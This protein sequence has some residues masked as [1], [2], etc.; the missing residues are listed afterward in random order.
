MM[1]IDDEKDMLQGL[2]RILPQ[3]LEGVDVETFSSAL[4]GLESIKKQSVDVL[5]LDI[6]MPE[7]DGMEVLTAVKEI[8]PWITVVMITAYGSIETAVEAIK[9]GAYDFITKPFEIPDLVRVLNKA[10]ERS[11]LIRENMNLRKKVSEREPFADFVGQ[12]PPM[13]RLYDGI[14]ALAGTDYTV[15]IRG[16]SGTGKEL[17]ARALHELSP[18][19]SRRMVTVNCP[20]IPEHLL[21]SE[22]FGHKKGAFTGAEQNHSGMFL[23]ADQSTLLLDE[24]GD[25]P[26]STQIKLLRVLQEREVRPLGSDKPRKVDVRILSCTNQDLEARIQDRSFRD[27]LYY[28]LNVV[29]LRTPSL[30]EITEDIPLLADHFLRSVCNELGLPQKRFSVAAIQSMMHKSWPGN[31]RELQNFLRRVALFSPE[32]EIGAADIRA[33]QDSLYGSAAESRQ[34]E[35]SNGK[36]VKPYQQAKEELLENF[37]REY[38]TRLLGQTEGN[39][40]RASDIAGI[41]RTALQKIMRRYEIRSEDFR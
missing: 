8:D 6:R 36:A 19:S 33:A 4:S 22:L 31:V 12:S 10:L 21:E 11:L 1:I 5:L 15:L 13:R 23:E 17:V 38:I 40:T 25:L 27:D 41:S 32:E 37:T 2:S 14:Q 20:A 35:E 26:V 30:S 28:R 18:R 39:V 9:K 34:G 24:I 3:E 29:T 16:E 7:M